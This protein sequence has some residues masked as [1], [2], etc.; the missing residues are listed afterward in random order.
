[1]NIIV[2]KFNRPKFHHLCLC[3]LVLLSFCLFIAFVIPVH[4]LY[5]SVCCFDI[6]CTLLLA[7]LCFSEVSILQI[8][9]FAL[10][11]YFILIVEKLKNLNLNLNSFFSPSFLFSVPFFS[12]FIVSFCFLCVLSCF[13]L[14]CIL[15]FS[16]IILLY[17]TSCDSQGAYCIRHIF[18]GVF[19]FA[20]FASRVLFANLST[21]ENIDLRFR[22]IECD[23]CTQYIALP[24]SRI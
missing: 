1:M 2:L 6:S 9:Y 18:R 19:I 10:V 17:S 3:T 7:L 5:L 24:R 15:M 12:F 20:N 16:S 21:R 8:L 4:I 23:L 11:L 14:H 22:H 13:F